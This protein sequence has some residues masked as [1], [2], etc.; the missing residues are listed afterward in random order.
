MTY[1][2]FKS[3][4][5][6]EM[7]FLSQEERARFNE[8]VSPVMH[9]LAVKRCGSEMGEKLWGYLIQARNK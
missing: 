7:N 3:G 1:E 4:L 8:I 5:V 6:T 2:K 9:D